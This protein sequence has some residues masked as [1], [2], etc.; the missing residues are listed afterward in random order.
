MSELTRHRLVQAGWLGAAALA[1]AAVF[2]L[3]TRP[4]FLVT[5]IDQIWACF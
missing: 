1:L 4:G 2:A 3:Y 5:L